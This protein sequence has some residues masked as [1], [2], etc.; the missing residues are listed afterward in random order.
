MGSKGFSAILFVF[1]FLFA[2]ILIGFF[3][4]FNSGKSKNLVDSKK[5]DAI[6]KSSIQAPF[7]AKA[8]DDIS[9]I[10]E[11]NTFGFKFTYAKG[12][13]VKEDSEA[14]FSKRG[15]TDFRK[16]FTGYI[17]Y[18]PPQFFG[19]V[20]VLDNGDLYIK[21]P[22]T[23]WVFENPDNMTIDSWYQKYWYYPFIWGDF[24]YEG[25]FKLSPQ[26]ESTISGSPVKSGVIDYQEGNPKFT[27]LSKDGKMYLFRT[28]GS[29][30]EAI[31]NT[32]TFLK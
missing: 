13:L 11:N 14:E 4:Y 16:N 32:F 20:V 23:I 6:E 18:A 22:F 5:E 21:N 10:Y 17:Q 1:L 30:G 12:F 27:Y 25:K 3:A 2:F 8:D 28:I 9:A 19:A 24:T 26:K 15:L 31:L 29:N 7:A